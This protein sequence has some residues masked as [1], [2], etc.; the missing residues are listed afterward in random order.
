MVCELGRKL[1][2]GLHSEDGNQWS[3]L[4]LTTCHK[5]GPPG[6]IFI[7]DLDNGIESSLTKLAEDTKLVGEV[8]TSEGRA[9][10]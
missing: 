3:L 2:L 9:I 7:N 1:G 4:R 8:D 6:N 10:L 5:W